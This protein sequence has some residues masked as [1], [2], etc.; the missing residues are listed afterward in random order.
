VDPSGH[1]PFENE[2]WI[3]EM[4]WQGR[5]GVLGSLDQLRQD[6]L[7]SN[8]FYGSGRDGNWTARDW[9]IYTQNREKY[10]KEPSSWPNSNSNSKSGFAYHVSRLESLYKSDEKVQFVRAFGLVFAG[11][12]YDASWLSAAWEARNGPLLPFLQEGNQG[13][14]PI[15]EDSI[16]PGSNQSHHYA[17]IF[18]LSYY[19]EPEIAIIVNLVRDPDNSGDISLGNK[20]A[21]DAYFY[22]YYSMP[23]SD[24]IKHIFN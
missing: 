5:G 13:L 18:F 10:W 23:L 3:E 15:Y 22:R 11:I 8:L 9:K 7:F 24:M 16:H 4:V 12:S 1:D 21:I 19:V 14:S 6:Y 17:G 20:A 2:D